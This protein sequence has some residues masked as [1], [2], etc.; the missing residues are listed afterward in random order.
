MDFLNRAI[1]Q[2]TDLFKSMTPAARVTSGLL[3]AVILV[4]LA[5][6]VN[7]VGSDQDA[8]LMGGEVFSSAQLHNME[9]AF[10]KAQLSEYRIEGNRIKVASGKQSVYMGCCWLTTSGACPLQP[11]RKY[12]ERT[13]GSSSIMQD[14]DLRRQAT[15]IATQKELQLILS[16]MRGIQKAAVMYDVEEAGPFGKNRIV[17][18]SVSVMTS[19]GLA[20]GRRTSPHDPPHGRT[21]HRRQSGQ[22]QRHRSERP[23]LSW[24]ER[25]RNH[26]RQ[27]RSLWIAET[28]V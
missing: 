11:S 24:L 1:G 16:N 17:T 12:L 4:S 2:I 18:A 13:V 14:K 25:R 3:L 5:F 27:R 15:K 21:G 7:Q 10:A 6:L 19:T 26:R 23:G 8:Y 9:A 20:A 22:H 28:N